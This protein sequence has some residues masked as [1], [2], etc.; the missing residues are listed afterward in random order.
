MLFI[1]LFSPVLSITPYIGLVLIFF[2]HFCL[3]F[4]VPVTV[5]VNYSKRGNG[6]S[7]FPSFKNEDAYQRVREKEGW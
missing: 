6:V 1:I 5:Q 3:S 7:M 4:S 2:F